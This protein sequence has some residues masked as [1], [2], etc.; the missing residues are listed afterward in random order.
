MMYE[1]YDTVIITITSTKIHGT[2]IHNIVGLFTFI[3][4]SYIY[5]HEDCIAFAFVFYVFWTNRLWILE[6]ASGERNVYFWENSVGE[7]RLSCWFF[8]VLV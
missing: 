2:H 4:T 8:L 5:I 7:E 3:S 1:V 6:M